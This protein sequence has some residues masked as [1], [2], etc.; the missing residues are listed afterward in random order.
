DPD[1]AA[2]MLRHGDDVGDDAVALEAEHGAVLP[3]TGLL[4]VDDQQHATLMAELAQPL[5][6]AR[7]RLDDAAGAEQRLGDHRRRPAGRLR[8][9]QLKA[10]VEASVAAGRERLAQRATIAIGRDDRLA[11]AWQR[12]VLLVPAGKSQRTR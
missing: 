10:G 5:Q 11:P 4:L 12:P 7:R 8:V 3:E 6:P 2:E 9:D 1:A